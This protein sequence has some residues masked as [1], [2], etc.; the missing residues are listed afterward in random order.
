MKVLII[1]PGNDQ[2][3]EQV[4]LA[5]KQHLHS[6]SR[7][8]V[9]DIV[10]LED[11]NSPTP[12][13]QHDAVIIGTPT[14]KGDIYWPLQ[15]A[16]DEVMQKIPREQISMKVATG[17]TISNDLSDSSR[18]LQAILWVFTESNARVLEPLFLQEGS[19]IEHQTQRI[20]DYVLGLK[21]IIT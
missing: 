9:V 11:L 16:V 10:S 20:N 18:N 5:F 6:A 13:E 15:V 21:G 1:I 14:I 7:R 17:F 8:I 2:R 19:N 4:A 3:L 12:I